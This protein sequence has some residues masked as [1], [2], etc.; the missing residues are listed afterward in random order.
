MIFV[1]QIYIEYLNLAVILEKQ[2]G[3]LVMRSRGCDGIVLRVLREKVD[4]VN[5]LPLT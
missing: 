1:M 4:G 5:M 2:D 3:T